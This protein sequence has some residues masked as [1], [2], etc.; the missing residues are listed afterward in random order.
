MKI[1]L[2]DHGILPTRAHDTDA[3]LDL[4]SPYTTKI[5]ARR[6]KKINTGV[7][8]Q[9]P[10][11]TVGFIK[12]KSGL[13]SKCGI[14]TDGTID[15]GYTGEIS[16]VLFNFGGQT[17]KIEA[18]DKIAQLVIVPVSYEKLEICDRLEESDRGNDGFGSTG[19]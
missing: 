5:G 19:R 9:L 15:E 1:K 8:I 2:D 6:F 7:H 13:M 14:L 3:G 12:S 4:Y 18:Y 16:I 17:Y 11:G 10:K